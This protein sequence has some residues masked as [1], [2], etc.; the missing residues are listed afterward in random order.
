MAVARVGPWALVCPRLGGVARRRDSE[1]GCPLQDQGYARRLG[2]VQST[3]G[4]TEALEKRRDT[5]PES[6]LWGCV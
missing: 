6:R 3:A 4:A 5:S 2:S 1:P